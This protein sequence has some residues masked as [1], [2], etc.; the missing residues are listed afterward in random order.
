ML[1]HID[2]VALPEIVRGIL[3]PLGC[4]RRQVAGSPTPGDVAGRGMGG[5][6]GVV[7]ATVELA[8][9]VRLFASAAVLAVMDAL[10]WLW[11]GWSEICRC[12]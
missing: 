2:V 9:M 4:K 5:D 8:V 3:V 6:G 10:L 7:I 11:A 12:C 1:R